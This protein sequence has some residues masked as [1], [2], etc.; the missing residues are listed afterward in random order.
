MDKAA[1]VQALQAFTHQEDMIMGVVSA[2]ALDEKAPEGFRP[3][4]IM[5]GAKSMIVFAKQLPLSLFTTPDGV[6]RMLYGRAAY[7]YYLIMDAAANRTS[8]MI[9]KAG[10]KA[11]PIPSYSPL[12][13][14]KG[15]PR[16]MIS[17]KHAAAEAGLGKLG[18][19]T[20]LIHPSYGN[21][22][23]LGAVMTDM[24]WPE[25]PTRQDA[26][27]C[28]DNCRAC[29]K[30][31]PV[32]A[33]RDGRV[34]KI[35][36]LGRCIKHVMLPPAFMLPLVKRVVAASPMMTRF[37]ELFS[38]NFFETYGIGCTACLKACI[39]FPGN[40]KNRSGRGEG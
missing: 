15:E 40:R 31:C 34:D 11:L 25:Y 7:T 28:P 32:N 30:A 6:S 17:L 36:C 9:E 27:T 23:R 8:I 26:G 21:I 19:N 3:R 22:M 2:E 39:H 18:R 12:R 20:L 5:P 4:D 24:E 10:G 13:F 35:A 16:G 38:L 1:V 29:E 33:I 37:M 14:H